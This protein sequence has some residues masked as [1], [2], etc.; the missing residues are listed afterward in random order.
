[1][2]LDDDSLVEE[3]VTGAR[4]SHSVVDSP[5]V[6]VDVP[7]GADK[8]GNPLGRVLREEVIAHVRHAELV[9]GI[10]VADRPE[11]AP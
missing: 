10:V 6:A 5:E 11:R 2:E 7:G 1:M 4:G 9:V 3:V 8:L